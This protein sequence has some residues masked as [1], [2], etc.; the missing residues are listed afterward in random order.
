METYVTTV[1]RIITGFVK[2]PNIMFERR[3]NGK[4]SKI[5]KNGGTIIWNGYLTDKET[6]ENLSAIIIYKSDVKLC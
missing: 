3:V 6:R 5:L 2:E 4:I 1:A